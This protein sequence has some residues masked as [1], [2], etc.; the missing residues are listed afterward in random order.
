MTKIA[1]SETLSAP[2]ASATKLGSPGVSIRL[3]LRSC[4]SKDESAAEIDIWRAFSS[5]SESETVLPS[6]TDPSRLI[7]PASNRSASCRKALPLPRWPTSATLRIRSA[8]L[9]MPVSS[10]RCPRRGK[11]IA[12]VQLPPELGA[13][14]EHRLGVQ[15]RDAGLGDAEDL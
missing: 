9:C 12:S 15:L 13:Q 10:P 2:S 8:A 5:G 3:T 4:H 7:A 11:A 14:P 1:D 6:G